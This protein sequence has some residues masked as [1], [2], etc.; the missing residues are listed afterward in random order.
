M[1]TDD[2]Y[3]PGAVLDTSI[4]ILHGSHNN[5]IRQFILV[6]IF[7]STLGLLD[8]PNSTRILSTYFASFLHKLYHNF[9]Y[10]IAQLSVQFLSFPVDSKSIKIVIVSYFIFI[11]GPIPSS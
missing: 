8:P 3:V 7:V 4:N 5:P 9:N 2:C 11:H 10:M 6:I 1:T